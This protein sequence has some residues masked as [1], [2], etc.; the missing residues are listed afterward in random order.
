V[1]NFLDSLQY[2]NDGIEPWEDGERDHPSHNDEEAALNTTG[3]DSCE[4]IAWAISVLRAAIAWRTG[5]LTPT[6]AN[7]LIGR[8]HRQR[9]RQLQ[10]HLKKL[11]SAYNS[12][13]LLSCNTF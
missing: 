6:D 13:C 9:I 7:N 11:E 4:N 12:K 8:G 3:A 2:N 1:Q 5:D 10:N